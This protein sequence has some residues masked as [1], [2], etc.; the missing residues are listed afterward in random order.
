MRALAKHL[1]EKAYSQASDYNFVCQSCKAVVK[2]AGTIMEA[3]IHIGALGWAFA[4]IPRLSRSWRLVCGDCVK[5]H[6]AAMS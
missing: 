2:T 5:E 1:N 3:T 6:D 4:V